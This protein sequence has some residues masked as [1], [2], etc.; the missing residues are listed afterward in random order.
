MR[1]TILYNKYYEK[2]A[3]FRAEVMRFFENIAQYN[4][5]VMCSKRFFGFLPNNRSAAV[6]RSARSVK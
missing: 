6:V 3:D 2:F 5:F 1:R 4:D